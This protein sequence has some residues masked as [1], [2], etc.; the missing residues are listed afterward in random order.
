MDRIGRARG[1]AQRA[2]G[3]IEAPGIHFGERLDLGA[4][5]PLDVGAN[6]RFELGAAADLL[7]GAKA[8]V[9]FRGA[10]RGLLG[11]AALLTLRALAALR[12]NA[13]PCLRLRTCLLYTSDAADE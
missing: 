9:L 5:E 6:A 4:H 7:L 3:T 1:T 12:F 2:I 10:Q 8:R 13:D 11:P